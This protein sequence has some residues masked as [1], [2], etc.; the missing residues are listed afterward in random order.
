VHGGDQTLSYL[1]RPARSGRSRSR[2]FGHDPDVLAA[3][4]RSLSNGNGPVDAVD[5][6]MGC[7]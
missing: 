7:R 4:A 1:E 5:V 2:S 3:G 6:N